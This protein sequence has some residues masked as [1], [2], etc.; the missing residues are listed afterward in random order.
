MEQNYFN[1]QIVD[2]YNIAKTVPRWGEAT[3]WETHADATSSLHNPRQSKNH[4]LFFVFQRMVYAYNIRK[5]FCFQKRTSVELSHWK[6]NEECLGKNNISTC[7][8]SFLRGCDLI[9]IPVDFSFIGN[10]P[11][12]TILRKK[13]PLSKISTDKIFPVYHLK[14]R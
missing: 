1:F 8:R 12:C 14:H 2:K 3:S 9:S 7:N 13:F 11:V 6:V 4:L 10:Y 5:K